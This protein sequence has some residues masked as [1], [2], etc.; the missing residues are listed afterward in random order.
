MS[1]K[2]KFLPQNI[3]VD[4][5]SDKSVMET[6]WKHGLPVQSSCKGKA[7]CAECR[8]FVT[9]GQRNLLPPTHNELELI[10]QGHFIDQRRLSCQLY[11]F[12]NVT[13][14]LSEQIE[15]EENSQISKSFLKK[16]KKEEGNKIHSIGDNFIEKNLVQQKK[17]RSQDKE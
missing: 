11:C 7:Q 2:I 1:F 5:E 8:V 14:D 13:I 4:V 12:G 6:A 15:K 16:I 9:E 17:N 3:E 10:G